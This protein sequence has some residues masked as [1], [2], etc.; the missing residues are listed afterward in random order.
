MVGSLSPCCVNGGGGRGL[1]PVVVAGSLFLNG[2][3]VGGPSKLF[4]T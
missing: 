1:S 3:G 4:S 2:G